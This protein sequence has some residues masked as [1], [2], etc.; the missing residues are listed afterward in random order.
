MRKKYYH[1]T[2]LWHDTKCM[3]NR[4]TN[5]KTMY[6][7]WLKLNKDTG[8]GRKP[9]GTIDA[10]PGWWKKNAKVIVAFSLHLPCALLDVL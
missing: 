10:T 4:V 8:L 7:F 1:I 5:L 9:D 2:N 3:K 6:V